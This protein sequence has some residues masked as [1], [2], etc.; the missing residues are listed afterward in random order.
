MLILVYLCWIMTQKNPTGRRTN[1]KTLSRKP[2]G[3]PQSQ[4]AFDFRIHVKSRK[5]NP[6]SARNP[7]LSSL[8]LFPYSSF[9]LA[10][11]GYIVL[12][13][14]VTGIA[15]MRNILSPLHPNYIALCAGGCIWR[16]RKLSVKKSII[17]RVMSFWLHAP[18]GTMRR[19]PKRGVIKANS[20]GVR[21]TSNCRLITAFHPMGPHARVIYC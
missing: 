3:F 10:A 12:T 19:V 21:K 7:R 15:L 8:S 13:A 11:R 6:V 9:T 20:S 1:K 2:K 5:P 17:I 14:R 4:T 18:A 16:A